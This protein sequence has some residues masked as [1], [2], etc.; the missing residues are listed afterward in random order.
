M[1]GV[2]KITNLINGDCYIGSSK[3]I[4][5]RWKQHMTL[6]C[7]KG[8][9]YQYHLYRAI[10]KYGIENFEFRI[11]ELCPEDNRIEL[12][13]K[14]YDMLLPKYNEIEPAQNPMECESVKLKQKIGCKSAWQN[15]REDKKQKILANLQKGWAEHSIIQKNPPKK[16]KAIRI[17]DN[18]TFLFDSMSD[19]GKKLNIPVSSISQ[20]INPNHA[21]KQTKGYR[22]VLQ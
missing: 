21:R 2:Y 22:F 20:I 7:K 1:T 18:E 11:L 16:V 15:S 5:Y 6:Y 3:D 14:Y 12:E 10:R 17:S 13:Q 9:H 8:R 19:A 4:A